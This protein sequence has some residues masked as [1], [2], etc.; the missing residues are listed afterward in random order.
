MSDDTNSEEED[1]KDEERQRKWHS[2]WEWIQLGLLF[3]GIG[4]GCFLFLYWLEEMKWN[5]RGPWPL[6]LLYLLGGKWLVGGVCWALGLLLFLHG[7]YRFYGSD[8]V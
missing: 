1:E 8:S 4:L 6:V 7:L 2:L 5:V 3:G